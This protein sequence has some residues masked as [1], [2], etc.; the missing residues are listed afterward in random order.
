M[1]VLIIDT[2]TTNSIEQ[3]LPYDV[4]YQIINI[5]TGQVLCERSFLISEIF[6]DHELMA[7]AYF[8]EK[9]P[10]YW[11]EVKSGKRILKGIFNIRKIIK[12]DIKEYNAFTIGAYNM[13]FDKRASNNN[14][15]FISGSLV[16]WF[17]PFGI[18]FFDI[19]NMACSSLLLSTEYINFCKENNFISESGNYSTSAENVYRFL[20]NDPNFVESH[21]GLEDVKIEAEIYLHILENY[22][23]YDDSIKP[24]CWRKVQ[25]FAKENKF[26]S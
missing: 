22:S 6:L 8:A 18:K 7:Q 17:F 12:A 16:R 21:T 4:G 26:P 2:E 3:P 11:K 15:R 13:S 20:I 9:I 10:Q 24:S 14:I 23:D 1:N 5:P 25:I 19:W